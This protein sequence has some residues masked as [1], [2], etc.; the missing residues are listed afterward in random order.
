MGGDWNDTPMT[1]IYNTIVTENGYTC[2]NF[3]AEERFGPHCSWNN[4]FDGN[5]HG[6]NYPSKN[7]GTGTTYLDYI[8]VSEGISTLKFASGRGK[9]TITDENGQPLTIYTSDHLPIIADICF[10]TEK[11]GS[12]IDPDYQE[13]EEDLS[14]P[15]YFT[16]RQDISWFTGDKTEYVLTPNTQQDNNYDADD[17]RSRYLIDSADSGSDSDSDGE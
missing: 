9:A 4:A 11:T 13:P 16:G 1:D 15:S 8:F 10:K 5:V 2:A 3:T 7:E 12:P 14:K 17:I 6:H